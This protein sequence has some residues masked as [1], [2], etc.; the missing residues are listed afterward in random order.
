MH[1]RYPASAD[2]SPTAEST[3]KVRGTCVER[4]LRNKSDPQLTEVSLMRRHFRSLHK[5]R[6]SDFL[7]NIT[8]NIRK[9]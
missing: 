2:M 4:G 3:T 9:N 5:R 6:Q 1:E 8:A 7:R